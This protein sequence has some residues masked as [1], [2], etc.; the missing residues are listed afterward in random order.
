MSVALSV[1][2]G[3]DSNVSARKVEVDESAVLFTFVVLI[4]GVKLLDTGGIPQATNK[5]MI[6]EDMI[7]ARFM[8]FIRNRISPSKTI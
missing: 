6:T 2:V 1:A 3:L 8:I 7:N 4:V 5:N